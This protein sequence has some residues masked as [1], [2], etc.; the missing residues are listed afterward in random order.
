M[1]SYYISRSELPSE[2]Y[3]PMFNKKK[4]WR[5]IHVVQFKNGF[6]YYEG[7]NL[8]SY[9]LDMIIDSIKNNYNNI[10]KTANPEE[11]QN[12]YYENNNKFYTY[13][14]CYKTWNYYMNNKELIIQII[15]EE[16]N[17]DES[18]ESNNTFDS[19]DV[20][21][22]SDSDSDN[23]YN[24]YNDFDKMFFNTVNKMLNKQFKN[25]IPDVD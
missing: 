20:S 23:H 9:N 2:I 25:E 13:T 12:Y 3:I 6:K 15:D 24:D 18:Y 21:F 11:L 4:D 10:I 17:N 22:S 14:E 1:T 7:V 19:T 5:Y 16:Y 8:Q